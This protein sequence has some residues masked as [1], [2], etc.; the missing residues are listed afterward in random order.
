MIELLYE[1]KIFGPEVILADAGYDC[2]KWFDV[3]DR[4]GIKFVAGINKRNIKDF[5]NVKN[6]LKTQNIEFLRSKEEQR[7]YKLRIKIERL[8]G[9]LKGE[10]SAETSTAKKF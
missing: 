10:Y 7:V 5:N 3:V 8:F 6:M 4:L 9:K 2:T 1:A